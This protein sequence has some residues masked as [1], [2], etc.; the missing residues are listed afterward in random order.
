MFFFWVHCQ[1]FEDHCKESFTSK[2]VLATPFSASSVSKSF[3]ASSYQMVVGFWLSKTTSCWVLPW[4]ATHAWI[5][6]ERM[7][8]VFS[9][10][11]G[12]LWDGIRFLGLVSP[13]WKNQSLTFSFINIYGKQVYVILVN[14]MFLFLE[15][16]SSWL[17]EFKRILMLVSTRFSAQVSMISKWFKSSLIT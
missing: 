4:I 13:T 9:K 12:N 14:H 10:L 3:V 16:I 17:V 5:F 1:A 15:F 6:L 7:S 11:V 2:L 8:W